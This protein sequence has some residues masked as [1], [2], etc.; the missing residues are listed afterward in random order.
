PPPRFGMAGAGRTTVFQ[1]AVALSI[2]LAVAV[3]GRMEGEA[4]T[5]DGMRNGWILAL[6]LFGGQ[7]LLFGL[8]YPRGNAAR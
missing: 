5:L 4:A 2:A 3:I 7:A 6:L 8:F 1:L